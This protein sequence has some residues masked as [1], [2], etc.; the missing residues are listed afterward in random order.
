MQ[1]V[2]AGL[3]LALAL[4]LAGAMVPLP[5]PANLG[6][7]VAGVAMTLC[8]HRPPPRHAPPAAAI[9]PV[10][11]AEPVDNVHLARGAHMMLDVYRAD[12]AILNDRQGLEDAVARLVAE[13]GMHLLTVA[14]YQL[15]PQGVSVAAVRARGH[16]PLL[17][18]V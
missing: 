11:P 6:W 3:S 8:V 2:R 12:A 14:S 1:R 16:P 13:A 7:L 10:A 9:T 5:S 18:H 17:L 15:E 4:A